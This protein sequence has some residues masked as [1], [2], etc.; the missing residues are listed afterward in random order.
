MTIFKRQKL[1]GERITLKI[2]K[3]HCTAC[4][5][6][7]DAELEDLDGVLESKTSFAKAETRVE[8]ELDKIGVDKILN[9]IAK[10]GYTARL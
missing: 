10:L 9:V 1:K 3:M 2:L 7:I 8:Y 4:A 6:N 5:I